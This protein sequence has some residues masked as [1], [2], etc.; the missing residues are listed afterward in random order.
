LTERPSKRP[1][2]AYCGGDVLALVA[3]GLFHP[4]PRRAVPQKAVDALKKCG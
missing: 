1:I 3:K 4:I 2:C